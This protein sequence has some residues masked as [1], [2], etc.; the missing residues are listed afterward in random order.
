MPKCAQVTNAW[1]LRNI[2]R[3][4]LRNILKKSFLALWVSLYPLRIHSSQMPLVLKC[5]TKSCIQLL[6]AFAQNDTTQKFL[7][8]QRH[9]SIIFGE[10]SFS[11]STILVFSGKHPRGIYPSR[12]FD[13]WTKMSGSISER[14]NNFR[15]TLVLWV[16]VVL[17]YLT[18]YCFHHH[19]SLLYQSRRWSCNSASYGT[20]LYFTQLFIMMNDADADCGWII[21]KRLNPSDG[22]CHSWRLPRY[23]ASSNPPNNTFEFQSC[24][25]KFLRQKHGW[26][27]CEKNELRSIKICDDVSRHSICFFFSCSNHLDPIIN[28][29][30]PIRLFWKERLLLDLPFC[31]N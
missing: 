24:G 4:S 11:F 29:F 8:H 1:V 14:Q 2:L 6:P 9:L 20:F 7:K 27:M 22:I 23:C 17:F 30:L 19:A 13:I 3:I 18:L 25:S 28:S 10:L 12:M 21:L 26:I 15:L 5:F 16:A 31:P